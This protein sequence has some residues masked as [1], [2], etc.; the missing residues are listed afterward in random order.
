MIHLHVGVLTL[1]FGKPVLCNDF[2]LESRESHT[3]PQRRNIFIVFV[4][5]YKSHQEATTGRI[6]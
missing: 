2:T 6:V 1:S 3:N 4:Q 5:C